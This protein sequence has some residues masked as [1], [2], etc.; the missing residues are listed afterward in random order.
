MVADEIIVL[1]A[2]RGWQLPDLAEVWAYRRLIYVL[3]KRDTF[4]KYRQSVLGFTWAFIPPVVQMLV[5]TLI[6]GNIAQIGPNGIPYYLFS[7]VGL[8]PWNYFSR[9]LTQTGGSLVGAKGLVSKVYFPRLVLP[10]VGVLGGLVELMIGMVILAI[11]LVVSGT[12][13]R[14]ELVF[15]PVFIVVCM[16]TVLSVGI[17]LAALGVKY[18]DITFITPFLLQVCMFLTPVIYTIEKIPERFQYLVWLNPMTGV[19]EGFRWSILGHPSLSWNYIGIS[20]GMI[21]ILLCSGLVYFRYVERT[22]VD[23]L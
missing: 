5:F 14:I 4:G 2:K 21:V 7:F 16:T 19:V 12:A 8:L 6:F 9:A 10:L 11:I 20:I 15:L 1:K 22:S 3:I 13:P 17:W 23:I 18:R